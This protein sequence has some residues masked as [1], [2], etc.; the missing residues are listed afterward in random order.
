MSDYGFVFSKAL[1]EKLK[2]KIYAGGVCEKYK[3]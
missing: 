3:R 2:E 1:H